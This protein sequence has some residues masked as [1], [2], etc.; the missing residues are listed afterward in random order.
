MH[1]KYEVEYIIWQNRA[2]RFYLAARVLF[3]KE[4]FGP[5]GF[6]TFQALENLLKATAIYHIANFNP[7]KFGHD[8]EAL[9]S[10]LK[11]KLPSATNLDIEPRLISWCFQ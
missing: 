2:F 1:A 4:L 10:E 3:Q 8:C 6:C 7:K 9:Q 5:A 11:A